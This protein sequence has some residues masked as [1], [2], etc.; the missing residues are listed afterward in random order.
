MGSQFVEV[1]V[2]TAGCKQSIC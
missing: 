1:I 2:T